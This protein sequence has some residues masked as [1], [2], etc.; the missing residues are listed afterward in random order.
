MITPAY[1]RMMAAYNAEMNRRLD[2]QECVKG[3]DVVTG[4]LGKMVIRKSRIKLSAF[5]INT[6]VHGAMECFFGPI[7]NSGLRIGCD[8]TGKDLPERGGDWSSARIGLTGITNVA[9]NTVTNRGKLRAEPKGLFVYAWPFGAGD[10]C[11]CR[12]PGPGKCGQEHEGNCD[13]S[14]HYHSAKQHF[15]RTPWHIQ[16]TTCVTGGL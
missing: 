6:F 4:C 10:R 14:C 9:I 3:V 1:V 16:E 2:D 12:L 11:D 5:A 7:P 13:N 15:S 8:V